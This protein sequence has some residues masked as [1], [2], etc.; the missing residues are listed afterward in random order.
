MDKNARGAMTGTRKLTFLALLTAMALGIFML[1]ARLPAP[2][3]VP[4]VKLGL[5]N[6]MTLTAMALMGR[7][8]AGLV[9]LMRVLLGSVFAGSF[10]A[11]LY[12][13][14]GGLLAYLCMCL[15][16]GLVPEKRLW[17]V[18]ALAAVCHNLGQL[19]VCV[20]VVKTPGI[21]WT[22]GPILLIS[23]VITGAFTGLVAMY[24]LRALRKIR[25]QV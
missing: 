20:L 14:A 11:I 23:G 17:A 5:A 18:S 12:S 4:G 9:L 1:E 2:V 19:I 10:S 21:F 6:V 13:A 3:P 16:I 8:E 7:K 24:L 22:Y 15:L 25:P